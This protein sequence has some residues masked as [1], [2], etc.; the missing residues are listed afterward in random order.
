MSNLLDLTLKT[1]SDKLAENIVSIDMRTVTPFTDYFVIATARNLRH[2]AS[3]A[4]DVIKA[5]EEEGYSLR[6]QEGTEGSS[7]ILVDLRDV[8]VHIF[9]ED[10]RA[11]YKL[12][13]LWGDLPAEPYKG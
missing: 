4:R 2:V 11:Q 6:M 13:H 7:W 8:I 9:T 1:L 3:L 10:T 12:E 5:A